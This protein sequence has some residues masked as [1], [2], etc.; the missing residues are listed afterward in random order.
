MNDGGFA[1]PVHRQTLLKMRAQYGAQEYMMQ[2]PLIEHIQV[3]I[4]CCVGTI[5]SAPYRI[6][7]KMKI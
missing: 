3:L 6:T 4:N 5:F 2:A 7:S 1:C